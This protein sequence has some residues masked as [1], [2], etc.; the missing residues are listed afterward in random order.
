MPAPSAPPSGFDRYARGY[1]TCL[2]QALAAT[3]EDTDYFARGRVRVMAQCL[4]QL[5]ASPVSVLDFGCGTGITAP[6]LLASLRCNDVLGVDS[7]S[8][9]IAEAIQT[10]SAAQI[11]FLT[12]ADFRSRTEQKFDCAYCNGVFHHIPPSD[13]LPA[14]RT[15][16]SALRSGGIFGFWENNPWNPGTRYVMSRCAFDDDAIT[17]SPPE[18]RR[19]LR[20]AGFEVLRTDYI[21]YFPRLLASLRPLEKILRK[22]PLGG[23]YQILCRKPLQ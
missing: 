13:R 8:E 10:Q 1:H 20:C 23:Q 9:S 17:L 11:R 22:L 7:S 19:L 3:G 18:G 6:I 12:L 5:N 4:S 16:F 15:I 14:A 2:N 21:F